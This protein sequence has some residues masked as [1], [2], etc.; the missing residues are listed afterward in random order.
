MVCATVSNSTV[1]NDPSH[2][3]RH[4]FLL[5][6]HNLRH[7]CFVGV[8]HRVSHPVQ[9]ILLHL[10]QLWGSSLRIRF[11]IC[12]F[13]GYDSQ[14]RVSQRVIRTI[15]DVYPSGGDMLDGSDISDPISLDLSPSL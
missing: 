6:H 1:G 10:S 3:D 4:R 11:T 7:F 8:L 2:R 12:N 9:A 13:S 14:T 15:F 5:R